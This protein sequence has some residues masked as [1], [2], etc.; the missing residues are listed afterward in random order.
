MLNDSGA[1]DFPRVDPLKI[2]QS[3]MDYIA[4]G[5]LRLLAEINSTH[6]GQRALE[7]KREE[8]LCKKAVEHHA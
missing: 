5:V 4:E 3:T 8:L 2:P 7:E 6:E 1:E